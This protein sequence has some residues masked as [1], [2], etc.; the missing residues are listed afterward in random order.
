MQ[1][2][3]NVSGV[4]AKK[5]PYEYEGQKYEADLKNGDRVK[6]LN[7]GEITVGQYGEKH[8][9]RIETRNGERLVDLNQSSINILVDEFGEESKNWAGKEVRVI[10]KKDVV[11][12]K[13]VIIVYLVTG[14][15]ELDDFG[16]LVKGGGF[17]PTS[18]RD[19]Q[20]QDPDSVKY[21]D[22]D[23]DVSQIPF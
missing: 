9:F 12:G 10:T 20:I 13:K 15:W 7:E 3:I 2:K 21:P 11:A 16:D 18:Q 8:T 5:E 17:E 22:E 23:I 1:K 6:L 19:A 4:Y 14:N